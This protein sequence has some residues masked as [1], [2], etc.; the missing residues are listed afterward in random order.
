MLVFWF[1]EKW[2]LCTISKDTFEEL[3]GSV[4]APTGSP[5]PL[6]SSFRQPDVAFGETRFYPPN[7][8]VIIN[9]VGVEVEGFNQFCLGFN[10]L[11]VTG[12]PLDKGLFSFDTEQHPHSELWDNEQKGL[13]T[14]V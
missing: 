5:Q 11:I 6:G 7:L 4:E 10:S 13:E 14:S 3:R 1:H 12:A 9:S 2:P 8:A